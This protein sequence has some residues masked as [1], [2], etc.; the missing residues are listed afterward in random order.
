MT[1]R[2]HDDSPSN[3]IENDVISM[4]SGGASLAKV[5][6]RASVRAG[7]RAS[8]RVGE[9]EARS[10]CVTHACDHGGPRGAHALRRSYRGTQLLRN[11]RGIP[12]RGRPAIIII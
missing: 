11:V 3:L 12:L 8:V 7:T 10:A 4:S 5:S 6:M 1:A 2:Y 9:K